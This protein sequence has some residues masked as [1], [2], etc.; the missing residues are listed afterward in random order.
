MSVT[1][2][3]LAS[4]IDSSSLITQLVA[5]ER[6]SADVL[7]QQQSDLSTQKSIVGSLSSA[8]SA[9]A[10]AARGMDLA[11]ELQPRAATTSDSHLTVA[12]S[13]GAAATTHSIRVEQL[14]RAQ[15][16]TSRTFATNT[17]GVLGTGGVTITTAGV[18]KSVSW[19]ATDTLDTIASKINDASTGA[20]AS[21]LY[22]GTN[23]R[24]VLTAQATGTAAAPTFTDSGDGLSL[25][26]PTTKIDAK[27]AK[28]MIDGIEV[29]RSKNIIDDAVAGLTI[30]AVSPHAAADPDASVGVSLDRDAVKAKIKA[31]VSAYS[32]VNS[33][34][35]VQ[36][37]YN[38]TKKG[39]NTLFGDATLR[40]LQGAIGTVMSNAYGDS[41]LSTIGLN[42][43]RDGNLTLDEAKLTSALTADPDAAA[44][45]FVTGGFTAAVTTLCDS[46]TRS[47]DGILA[48]KTSS[49]DARSATLQTQ[50]D[51]INSNADSLKT[52]LET[53]FSALETA[54][55]Q[56]QSQAAYIS[57]VLG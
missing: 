44:K 48:G 50:I 25:A 10:T 16:T 14:A 29:T 41:N 45:L 43:D 23:Y 32:S 17:A 42:R 3:G 22:D 27:D 1:F 53:Q 37:D 54:M 55:S 24:L 28:L 11:S 33:A 9:L 46:Y 2:S 21:V 7:T 52:R 34:L 15:V 35:H 12:A 39:T 36:L 8:L 57:R 26:N 5:A 6:S 4:G 31:L 56:L 40:Q 18:A 20:T 19:D 51:R 13:A 47:G 30:T 38:G 49:M